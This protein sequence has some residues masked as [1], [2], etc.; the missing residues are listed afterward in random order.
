MALRMWIIY[1]PINSLHLRPSIARMKAI[2][3]ISAA[4]LAN[5]APDAFA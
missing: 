1:L 4:F 2:Q 3:L 5:I